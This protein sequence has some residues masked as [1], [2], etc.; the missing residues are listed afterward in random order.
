ITQNAPTIQPEVKTIQLPETLQKQASALLEA[1]NTPEQIEAVIKSTQSKIVNEYEK[2]TNTPIRTAIEDF[3]KKV[4]IKEIQEQPSISQKPAIQK[5][6]SS[7]VLRPVEEK[8]KIEERKTVALPN[9]DIGEITN[10]RQDIATVNANGKEYRRKVDELIESP[11]PHKELSDLYNDLVKGI[12]KETGQQVSRAVNYVGFNP[13]EKSLVVHYATPGADTYVFNDLSE[14]RV[15]QLMGL[16]QLRRGSGENYIGAFEQGSKSVLG[17]KLHDLVKELEKER[18]GKGKAHE[19]TYKTLYDAL[20]PGKKAAHER[21]KEK[22]VEA[23]RLKKEEKNKEKKNVK[24]R[25]A[26]KPRLD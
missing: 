2:A 9:G 7:E 20:E 19:F 1:G 8:P 13:E 10:I 15:K 14:N 25:K 23:S 22:Q 17:S 21:H 24:K 18:G 3:I 6:T 4:P 12:E 16:E 5:P 11:L 26:Q